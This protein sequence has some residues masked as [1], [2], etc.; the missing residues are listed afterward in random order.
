MI[1]IF[2]RGRLGLSDM[3][4]RALPYFLS[5]VLL[6]LSPGVGKWCLVRA[7]VVGQG[8]AYE[9]K[10]TVCRSLKK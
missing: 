10:R 8:T 2:P 9:A 7:S 1:R 3:W 5:S 6:Y 4:R